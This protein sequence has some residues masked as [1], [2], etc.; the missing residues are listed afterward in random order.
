METRPWIFTRIY[1]YVYKSVRR[2]IK[3]FRTQEKKIVYKVKNESKEK[4]KKGE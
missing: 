2:I 3:R 4:T 1:I